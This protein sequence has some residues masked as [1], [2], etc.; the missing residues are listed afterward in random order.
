MF[1]VSLNFILIDLTTS[2]DAGARVTFLVRSPAVF[3]NDEVIQ[4]Y[5]KADK[6]I[7][8]RGDGLSRPDVQRAWDE[9]GKT[10]PVDVVLFSVGRFFGVLWNNSKLI[11][12]KVGNPTSVFLKDST[13]SHPT[14]LP[15]ALSIRCAL[16]QLT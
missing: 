10:G 15:N 12:S 8:V 2:I 13:S 11:K 3:D 5:I 9:A 1:H 6:A 14:L 7:L 4:R 16:F